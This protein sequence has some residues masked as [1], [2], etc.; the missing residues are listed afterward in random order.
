MKKIITISREFG[1]GGGEISRQVSSRLGYELYDKA[2]IIRAAEESNIDVGRVNH[3]DESVPTNFGFAQSLF[4][5]YNR[6]MDE[7]LF[8][9]QTKVIHD[10]GEHGRC[11][12]LGRN[13]NWIL[14]EFDSCL[15]VFIGAK[16]QWRIE[17]IHQNQPDQ[18]YAR[19]EEEM[20]SIDRR[21]TK[22]CAHYTD[23][24]F[25]EAKAY[26]LCLSTSTLGID[27]CVDIICELAQED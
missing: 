11:V 8:A 23:Y 3:W 17:R 10:L 12:I 25:G 1:A 2:L 20:H 26:D 6:P 24:E 15:H 4:N 14:K 22:Y 5:F 7:K 9:A 16:D 21:R 27:R 18:T 13:A 19:I